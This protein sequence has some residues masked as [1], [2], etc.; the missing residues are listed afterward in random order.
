[1]IKLGRPFG[2]PV[3]AN[4]SVLVIIGL[5]VFGLTGSSPNPAVLVTALVIAILFLGSLLAHELAHALTARRFG[6]TTSNVTLWMLGG[7][8]Q[9]SSEIPTARAQLTIALAG[10]GMSVALAGGFA[11]LALAAAVTLGQGL[12]FAALAWLAVTNVVLAVFNLLPAAPLDGGRVLAGIV[13]ATTGNREKAQSIAGRA[14]Q[15]VGVGLIGLGVVTFLAGIGFSGLWFALIGWFVFSTASFERRTADQRAA[16]AD[17]TVADA[18]VSFAPAISGWLHADAALTVATEPTLRDEPRLVLRW[19]GSFA[20]VMTLTDL[21]RLSAAKATARPQDVA[22]PLGP[23]PAFRPD[24]PLAEVAQRIPS[25]REI[26]C[27]VAN[28]SIDAGPSGVVTATS[29]RRAADRVRVS[30]APTP[31]A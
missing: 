21:E 13:W 1:M 11:A 14:G 17:L 20:G 23:I 31:A 28:Q 27:V 18:A 24:A 5:L 10:P 19:D 16:F 6:V 7:V 30:P 9:L 26:W 8:A 25:G 22:T 15:I 2:I 3:Q 29:A 4:W 12:L